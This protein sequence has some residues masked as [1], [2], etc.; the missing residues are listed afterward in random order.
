MNF[1]ICGYENLHLHSDFSVLDGYG[2]PEEYAARAPTINQQFLSI[3]DH[4]QMGAIPQQ[5]A[6]C[7]RH[8]IAPLFACELYLNDKHHLREHMADLSDDE[9][10][11]VRKSYHLLAIAYSDTGYKN[12]VQLSSWGHIHGFYFKP[13]VTYEQLKKRK[14][15]IIFTSC[16]ING[17]IGNAFL[18]SG[19]EAAYQKLEEYIEMFGDNFYLEL[20]MLDYDKQRPYDEFLVEAHDKYHIPL[21]ITCDTHYPEAKDSK[22]QRYMLMVQTGRTIKDIQNLLAMDDGSTPFELQDQ[23]LWMKSESEMNDKWLSD[24]KDIIPYELFKQAKR[25]T[26]V[27][28]QKAKGVEF[29]R[30]MKLPYVEDAKDKLKEA[31]FQGFKWRGIVGKKEYQAR[32]IEEYEL[33]C[34]KGFAS[35]FLIQKQIVDEARRVCPKLLGWGR[36]DE[37]LGPGR[38][39]GPASLVNYLLGIT[40]VDPI[41]HKLL[42]SR[43]LSEA[44]GGRSMKIRFSGD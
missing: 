2:K 3:S 33:I 14:E 18:Q 8:G 21:I 20:M 43:F 6:A 40:D 27:I 37:A 32:A 9:K 34:R 22:Y 15:G 7:E 42:F 31:V 28:A 17:E 4:G 39:S 1:E 24:Y 19:K 12:L 13:R 44:R 23:N 41:R 5:I 29:D 38:G 10:K 16:C 26:V 30:S 35:Y 25:N 11:Q 36:G